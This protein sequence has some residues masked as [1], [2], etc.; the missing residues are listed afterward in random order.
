MMNE[1]EL[2]AQYKKETGYITNFKAMGFTDEYTLWLEEQV[3]NIKK[4]VIFNKKQIDIV[5]RSFMSLSQTYRS[6]LDKE[7]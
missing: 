6:L 4:D 7:L 2:R 1:T 5:I 3:M